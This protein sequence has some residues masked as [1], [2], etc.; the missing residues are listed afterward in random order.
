MLSKLHTWFQQSCLEMFI[1]DFWQWEST[2]RSYV[3]IIIHRIIKFGRGKP[4]KGDNAHSGV[5]SGY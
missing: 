4:R 3:N 2:N 1:P 5:V